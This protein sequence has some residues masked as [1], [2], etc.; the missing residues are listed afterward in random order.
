MPG[1]NSQTGIYMSPSLSA[2]L[3]ASLSLAL[4]ARGERNGKKVFRLEKDMPTPDNP[5]VS[6][7]AD[8]APFT[9]RGRLCEQKLKGFTSSAYI[10]TI[11][12]PRAEK[13][14]DTDFLAGGRLRGILK[15][16]SSNRMPGK[17]S[18]NSVSANLTLISGPR[19][20]KCFRQHF[21]MFPL[22]HDII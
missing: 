16:T 14:P 5:P 21:F 13:C 7:D 4:S 11:S 20:K 3:S 17:N 9:Q 22:K 12:S 19:A 1:K 15:R 2:P 18:Q 8:P 6:A 10:Y